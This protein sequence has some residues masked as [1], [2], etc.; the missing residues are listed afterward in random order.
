[1][2]SPVVLVVVIV[3]IIIVFYPILLQ[4]LSLKSKTQTVAQ[5]VG[6]LPLSLPGA[7]SDELSR[8]LNDD[9]LDETLP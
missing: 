3:V 9:E 1:M 4:L 7:S 5:A 8:L 2:L 6:S